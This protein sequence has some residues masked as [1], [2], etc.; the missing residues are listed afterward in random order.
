[1]GIRSHPH[2]LEAITKPWKPP[3]PWARRAPRRG[4]PKVVGGVPGP[5]GLRGAFMRCGE[6]RYRYPAGRKARRAIEGRGL[7]VRAS[8]ERNMKAHRK[9]SAT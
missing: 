9:A 5:E 6:Y 1:M 2:Q 7:K 8:D 4:P 3:I